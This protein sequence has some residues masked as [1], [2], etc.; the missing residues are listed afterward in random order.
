MLVDVLELRVLI[1]GCAAATLLYAVGWRLATRR[2]GLAGDGEPEPA[3]APSGAG[4]GPEGT[5]LA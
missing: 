1:A 4:A 2:I 3:G 5:D